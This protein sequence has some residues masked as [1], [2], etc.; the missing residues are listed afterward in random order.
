MSRI[1]LT[2][3]PGAWGLYPELGDP[4]IGWGV[5]HEE[6]WGQEGASRLGIRLAALIRD[7]AVSGKSQ[8]ICLEVTLG[9]L[10]PKGARPGQG[11][12]STWLPP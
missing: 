6:G 11:R 10:V 2:A 4:G 12:A 1:Y 5:E 3:A 9:T 8:G 7:G